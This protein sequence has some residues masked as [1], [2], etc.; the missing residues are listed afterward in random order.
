MPLLFKFLAVYQG[1]E[2]RDSTKDMSH[3]FSSVLTGCLQVKHCWNEGWWDIKSDPFSLL[4]VFRQHS[5]SYK[6]NSTSITQGVFTED[7]ASTGFPCSHLRNASISESVSLVR[8]EPR[9]G[10]A[11]Q[12]Q[13]QLDRR[14]SIAAAL[15]F[16][17]T[18]Y[19]RKLM[20]NK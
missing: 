20:E 13:W 1:A 15:I 18:N 11:F 16:D 6:A 10:S 17:I 19:S 8:L 4:D 2:V 9:I 12:S 7:P 14:I 5:P 3:T